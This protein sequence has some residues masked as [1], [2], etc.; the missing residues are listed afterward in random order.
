MLVKQVRNS[1]FRSFR[2]AGGARAFTLVEMLVSLFVIAIALTIVVTAFAVTTRTTR[3]AAAYA[4]V[5]NWVRQFTLQLEED[6]KYVDPAKSVL[7]VV[8][9]TQKAS[10]NEDLRQA[11]K[12]WRVLVGDPTAVPGGFDPGFTQSSDPQ[13][14]QYSD[15]RA[16]LLMFFT[17]RPSQSQAPAPNPLNNTAQEQ[18]ANGARSSPIQ[19]VYGHAAYG[20]YSIQQN[21]QAV[22]TSTLRHINSGPT[23]GNRRQTLSQLSLSQWHLARRATLFDMQTSPS[24][25]QAPNYFDFFNVGDTAAWDALTRC[26]PPSDQRAADVAERFSLEAFLG[27][28]GLSA[29]PSGG[30]FGLANVI[31]YRFDT[32]P[33]AGQAATWIRNI[34]YHPNGQND[35][36][37]ATILREPPVDLRTNLGVQLLPGCAWFQVEFLMPE[38]ALNSPDNPFALG[39]TSQRWA[40]AEDGQMC[41][42]VPDS[43]ENRSYVAQQTPTSGNRIDTFTLID[44][45]N[46]PNTVANRRIR[47]WPYAIRVT[48]RAFDPKG[49]LPEPIV[50]SMIHRFP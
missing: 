50:R 17:N 11:G 20:D 16:D 1:A 32:D 31:P 24:R 15:P 3:Q 18:F 42:F 43:D 25:S 39:S 6:L 2:P 46:Q 41:V 22:W 21:G 47:M 10:L 28:A 45:T 23:S 29:P 12:A 9:R 44:P 26:T 48:V 13:V 33:N 5:N 7:V 19:V 4:E 49:R 37:V 40:E 8:G 30:F 36:H 38:D 35:F 27:Q 34:L 14:T